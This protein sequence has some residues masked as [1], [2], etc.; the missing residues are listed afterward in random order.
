MNRPDPNQPFQP[1]EKGPRLDPDK[2]KTHFPVKGQSNVATTPGVHGVAWVAGNAAEDGVGVHADGGG[3]VGL[4]A[5]SRGREAV[6]AESNAL[7]T[8]AVAAR[9]TNPKATGA[10]IF[11]A[12]AGTEGHAGFFD[13]QVWISGHLRVGGDI[14]LANAD[15]AED[16][17]VTADRTATPGTVM[18]LGPDGSVRPCDEPYDTRVAG[19]VSGA[20][21][22]RPGIV[23]DRR[24]TSARR[25][26]L[27]LLGKVYCCVDADFAPVAG[28]DLL[29][30]S[31]TPGHAMRATDLSRCVGA[32]VAKALAPLASGRGVIPVL[33]ALR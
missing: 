13:G 19:V 33:V 16:F 6:R 14:T 4:L 22:F 9:L 11:A 27:A 2:V 30:T 26:P 12:T 8:G 17:D 29:T 1:F 18:V 20:P 23:L 24:E 5:E 21:G 10:A 28:G 15:V 3:G 31:A 32:I 25:A 7:R